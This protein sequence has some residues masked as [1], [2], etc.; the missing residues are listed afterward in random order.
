[1]LLSLNEHSKNIWE[2][3]L[4]IS[5]LNNIKHS[6]FRL[7]WAEYYYKGVL[8]LSQEHDG[9]R[10]GAVLF[11]QR[12]YAYLTVRMQSEGRFSGVL[13]GCATVGRSLYNPP[14]CRG[15]ERR[16]A[17]VPMQAFPMTAPGVFRS[18]DLQMPY[19]DPCRSDKGGC[20][21]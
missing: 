3:C 21:F 19:R 6:Y 4:L 18:E 8:L 14:G 7:L 2:V 10:E 16:S 15:V 11:G 1:M 12:L 5:W 9:I 17:M 13:N 20:G